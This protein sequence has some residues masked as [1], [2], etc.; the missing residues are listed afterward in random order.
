M[1]IAFTGSHSTG[2]TTLIKEVEKSLPHT[3]TIKCVT[4]VA[5]RIIERGCPLNNDATVTSYIHYINDQLTEERDINCYDIFFS[6][7]TL[8]D[9]LAYMIANKD[10]P[11]PVIE[12]Y[13][14]EMMENVWLL[15]K[16]RFDVY[17]YFPI[18]F[19]LAYDGIRPSDERYRAA[20][21]RAILSVLQKHNV[22]YITITGSLAE[23]KTQLMRIL[24][25]V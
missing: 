18:E 3:L 19:P 25:L 15:E 10:F 21:D 24:N 4:E 1:K 7:R 23:R 8:L 22:N 12:D 9:P 2:K 6:D 20:V 17:L 14:I 11:G 16:E 5:R 13:F